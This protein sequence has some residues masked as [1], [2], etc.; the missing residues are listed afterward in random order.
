MSEPKE[1]KVNSINYTFINCADL[2]LQTNK[3]LSKIPN[4]VFSTTSYATVIYILNDNGDVKCTIVGDKAQYQNNQNYDRRTS[5]VANGFNV[6]WDD[7]G[8]SCVVYRQIKQKKP[9]KYYILMA[10]LFIVGLVIGLVIPSNSKKSDKDG[11]KNQTI[12]VQDTIVAPESEDTRVSNN[13][14]DEKPDTSSNN[15]SKPINNPSNEKSN[16][17]KEENLKPKA[18]PWRAKVWAEA[19]EMRKQLQLMS[20]TRRTVSKVRK[21]YFYDLSSSARA[22]VKSNFGYDFENALRAYEAFFNAKSRED[23][24]VVQ[25][26]L[27]LFSDSQRKAIMNGFLRDRLMCDRLLKIKDFDFNTPNRAGIY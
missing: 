25:R 11:D 19:E 6:I 8:K 17:S 7:E 14:L 18:E 27:S 16:I 9:T 5:N 15:S 24:T 3:G 13:L 2:G 20:C 22:Y 12:E 23:M 21:W 4:E 10:I 1:V 26:H